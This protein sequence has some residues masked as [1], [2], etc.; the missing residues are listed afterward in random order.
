[1]MCNNN[2]ALTI[3]IDSIAVAIAIAVLLID[4]FQKK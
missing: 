2:K 1:M 4:I 3:V